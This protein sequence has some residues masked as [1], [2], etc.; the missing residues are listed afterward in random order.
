MG[1]R[2]RSKTDSGHAVHTIFNTRAHAR[3]QRF[4][5]A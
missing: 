4:V 1:R 5:K 3:Y 2:T